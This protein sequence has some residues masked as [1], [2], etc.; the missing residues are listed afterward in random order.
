MRALR[1]GIAIAGLW[2]AIAALILLILD[3]TAP[4][5]PEEGVLEYCAGGYCV[6]RQPN[7]ER[8]VQ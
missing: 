3:Q 5:S 4:R 2:L 1:L 8:V 7:G 6:Y